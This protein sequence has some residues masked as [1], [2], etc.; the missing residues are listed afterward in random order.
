MSLQSPDGRWSFDLIGKN[1]TSRD[2]LTFA[3][4]FPLSLGSVGVSKQYPRNVA[5]QFQFH[6][7]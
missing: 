3:Q 7:K 1:L 6:F 2:I 4:A 5:G